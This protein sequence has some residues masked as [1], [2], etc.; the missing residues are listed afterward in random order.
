MEK[1]YYIAY[2][3]N[4]NIRQ[5]L[6]RCPTARIVGTATIKGYE[7]LYKGSKTGAYLTIEP[8]EGGKVPVAVW[9]VW[10]ADVKSLDMYEGYPNFY[11][12][13]DFRLM[14]KR[15]DGTRKAYDVFAYIM[16]EERPL[17]EPS[18]NYIECCKD[19][20]DDFGFDKKILDEAFE[21]SVSAVYDKRVRAR[22][23][24]R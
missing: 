5:M 17:G 12:K 11:Y 7:L 22:D 18:W 4:L 9:S 20:Y 23:Y 6:F 2:G 1:K 3:S 10:P 16:H 19:G 14:V 21:R 8:K 15:T 13:Q 24:E